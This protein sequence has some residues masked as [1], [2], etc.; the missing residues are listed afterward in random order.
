MDAHVALVYS[1]EYLIDLWGFER[2]HSFDVNKYEKIRRELERDGLLRESDLHRPDEASREDLLL[3]HSEEHLERLKS[4]HNVGWYLEAP[5]LAALPG[6]IVDARILKPF[7]CATGGTILAGRL[8]LRHGVAVNIGGGYHHAK[9]DAGEG[10][11]V[12]AD[13]A[14]AIRRL[15]SEHLVRRSAVVDL[16]V[17]Q[18]N[19]TA[20]VFSADASV[21]TFSMHEGDI[22][23]IPK[24]KSSLDVELVCGTDDATYLRLLR[25]HL[26]GVLEHARPDL[27]FFQAGCDTLGGDPLANLAMTKEGIVERDAMVI[28][29]CVR[30]EIP[31]AMTLGG[32]YAPDSWKVQYASIR[33]TI[34]TYG[35]ARREDPA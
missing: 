24:A 34:E 30:R 32:G 9:P 10:F 5:F 22:F 14:I 12:Y 23:P 2:L 29:E 33:R 6:R 26:P 13:I 31:V 4:A 27:V 35:L 20:T 15:R 28:D 16:D 3:V 7:R 8:A 19:G 25:E 1:P 17:H 11:N 18:G 21:F